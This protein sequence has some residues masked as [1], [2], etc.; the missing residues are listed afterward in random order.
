MYRIKPRKFY[1]FTGDGQITV[2]RSPIQRQHF[3]RG[4]TAWRGVTVPEADQTDAFDCIMR[5]TRR[6]ADLLMRW[7]LT[8]SRRPA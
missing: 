3:I 4:T 6:R 1:C 5:E 7:N 8:V 2:F